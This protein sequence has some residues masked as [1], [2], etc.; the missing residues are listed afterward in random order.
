M[1]GDRQ[2]VSH[3]RMT[4][5]QTFFYGRVAAVTTGLIFLCVIAM[6]V[7][8]VATGARFVAFTGDAAKGAASVCLAFAVPGLAVSVYRLM[9]RVPLVVVDSEGLRV[10][11]ALL[12]M[13]RIRWDQLRWIEYPWKGGTSFRVRASV[14]AIAVY[15]LSKADRGAL[16]NTLSERSVPIRPD[17]K[18]S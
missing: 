6:C 11:G 13:R 9:F 4:E 5:S 18:P 2:L 15:H 7:W 8:I 3:L 10:R 17:P 1:G 16:F 14:G 12:G